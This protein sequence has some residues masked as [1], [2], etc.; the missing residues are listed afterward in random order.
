[1]GAVTTG[2]WE[3]RVHAHGCHGVRSV[4]S[5]RWGKDSP[6][7]VSWRYPWEAGRCSMGQPCLL[8]HSGHPL[9]YKIGEGA[10]S[11]LPRTSAP[12][13]GGRGS[14]R[15]AASTCA[16]ACSRAASTPPQLSHSTTPAQ[17]QQVCVGGQAVR[18]L[19]VGALGGLRGPVLPLFITSRW[20]GRA[21]HASH[22]QP[23]QL[24]APLE[25]PLSRL[26]PTLSA[27]VPSPG[28]HHRCTYYSSREQN[29]MEDLF[30]QRLLWLYLP[31][32]CSCPMGAKL[33]D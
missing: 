33:Q 12:G 11:H 9:G 4:G 20:P 8:G 30:G 2:H 26:Q 17:Q 28:L 7:H 23:P 14:R 24:V 13:G 21:G 32:P 16:P 5:G 31:L 22:V 29:Q 19:G 27:R 3:R 1:M 10:R 18:R 6:A 25:E 15:G